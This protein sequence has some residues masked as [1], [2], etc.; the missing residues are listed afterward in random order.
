MNGCCVQLSSDL[1]NSS[2]SVASSCTG[3]QKLAPDSFCTQDSCSQTFCMVFI[4]ENF[5]G[6][7]AFW[8]LQDQG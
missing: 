2:E 3:D 4:L 1:Q 6:E 7:E 5:G 8:V